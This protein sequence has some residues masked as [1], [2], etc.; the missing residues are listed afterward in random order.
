MWSRGHAHRVESG[1]DCT[2]GRNSREGLIKHCS[3]LGGAR[4]PHLGG[5]L[6][7]TNQ[8]P[9]SRTSSTV[10]ANP[11]SMRGKIATSIS[12]PPLWFDTPLRGPLLPR[13]HSCRHQLIGNTSHGLPHDM[14]MR[15]L[16]RTF[17]GVEKLVGCRSSR[18]RGRACIET[19][20]VG[21]DCQCVSGC[22]TVPRLPAALHGSVIWWA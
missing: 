19:V 15:G 12:L 3:A 20:T 13:F 2:A 5:R 7:M 4:C 21:G 18:V 22:R 1:R 14:A 10:V 6:Y 11:A 17:L 9:R 16:Y 8:V